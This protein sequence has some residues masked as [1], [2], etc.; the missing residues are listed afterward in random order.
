M[1]VHVRAALAALG[2]LMGA[3][4]LAEAQTIRPHIGPRLSYDF[5]AEE[6][7]IG[8]QAGIP[9]GQRFELYPSIDYF[10][11]DP[12]SLWAFNADLKYRI[13]YEKAAWLYV[14]TGLNLETASFNDNSETDPGLNLMVG[15]EP[16]HNW[17]H[18]FGEAR[19]KLADR[20]A[21]QLMAGLNITLRM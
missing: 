3:V 20:T 13:A 18:P 7:G 21:F 5:D 15:A 2:I 11:V 10:F 17:I 19:L 9:L 8:A 6:F 14:G 16:L 1:R 4:S 12:G